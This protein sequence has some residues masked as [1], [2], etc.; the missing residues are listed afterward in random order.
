[1]RL[2]VPPKCEDDSNEPGQLLRQRSVPHT[3]FVGMAAERCQIS[4]APP[5]L[6]RRGGRVWRS[7][8]AKAS[9]LQ[10]NKEAGVSR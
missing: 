6:S 8:D 1:V 5:G 10:R 7:A 2:W 4:R 9:W 3:G